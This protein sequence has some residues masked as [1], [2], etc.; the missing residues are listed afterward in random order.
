MTETTTAGTAVPPDAAV[1]KVFPPL[2]PTTMIPQLF[3]LAVFLGALYLLL[4]RIALPRIGSVIEERRDR[5]QRDIDQAERLKSDVDEAV[6]AY[7]KA[8]SDARGK[9]STI[10]RETSDKLGAEVD[11]ER[12]A[13]E[14]ETAAK[15]SSAEARI[16][17]TKR[18]ALASVNEIAADI[19]GPIVKQ[20]IGKDVS[21]DEIKRTAKSV[22]GE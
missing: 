4:S 20:L 15:L 16:N 2:D 9:A 14:A 13:V 6:K 5:I 1:V 12:A 11:K 10:A 7:E 3:W 17:E 21:A 8:L 19:A 22:A 18:K